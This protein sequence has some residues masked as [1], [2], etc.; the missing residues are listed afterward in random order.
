[1]AVDMIM[2]GRLMLYTYSERKRD[3]ALNVTKK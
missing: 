3:R 1:V 2:F